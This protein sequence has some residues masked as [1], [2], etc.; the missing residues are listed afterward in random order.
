[1]ERTVGAGVG[2]V[3]SITF[4][5]GESPSPYLTHIISQSDAVRNIKTGTFEP[6][7][8]SRPA[9]KRIKKLY[10]I[11]QSPVP[12]LIICSANLGFHELFNCLS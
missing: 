1:M 8:K 9:D 3:Y 11:Y 5:S 2:E 12:K 7:F 6:L 10:C 4:K